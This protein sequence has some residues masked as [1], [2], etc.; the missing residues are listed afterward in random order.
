MVTATKRE[1]AWFPSADT[2]EETAPV[3]ELNITITFGDLEDEF[4]WFAEC[5]ELPLT[6]EGDTP[7]EA[8]SM[9]LEMA[10][11]YFQSLYETGGWDRAMRVAGLSVPPPDRETGMPIAI[12]VIQK[13]MVPFLTGN[14]G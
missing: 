5:Q 11:L 1:P 9:L 2:A 7:R 14:G 13:G 12:N 4:P 8:F 6:G 3:L 10:D